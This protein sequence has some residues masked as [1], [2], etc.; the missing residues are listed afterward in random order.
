MEQVEIRAIEAADREWVREFF[1]THWGSPQMVYSKGIHE[2][3]TLPGYVV[4]VEESV[5][6]V[7][8]YAVHG[9]ECE[10]VSLDSLREGQGIGTAL[11]TAVERMAVVEGMSRVWLITTNDNLNALRFYQKRDYE[12][13]HIYR[14]A[15]EEARKIKPQIPTIGDHGIP[16]RDEIE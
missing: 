9:T 3:D 15:V 14:N 13:A 5:V 16:I 8:T 12:L 11:I 1:I 2:C 6:G 7:I 10:I 4:F